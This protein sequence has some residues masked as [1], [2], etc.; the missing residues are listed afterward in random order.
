MMCIPSVQ[1][2]AKSRAKIQKLSLGSNLK[3][4]FEIWTKCMAFKDL[5]WNFEVTL[6]VGR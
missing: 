3:L 6:I 2:T 4:P 1:L 5:I